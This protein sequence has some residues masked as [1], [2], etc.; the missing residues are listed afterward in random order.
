MT[1]ITPS[2]TVGQLVRERPSRA[3]VFERLGLDYCCGGKRSLAAACAERGLDAETVVAVLEAADVPEDTAV[4]DWSTASVDELC[5]HIVGVHHARLRE[6]LPR[7]S[8]LLEKVERAH[9]AEQPE[10]RDVRATFEEL[11]TELEQHTNE[12]ER[13]LFPA[14]RAAASGAAE[15]PATIPLAAFEDEH[16]LA[17][18]LLAR[19]SELTGG[20]DTGAARCNTHRAALDALRALQADLHEHIHEENNL[21]FPRFT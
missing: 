2:T 10:L 17:G 5:D 13:V 11:R 3:R 15:A 9:G 16:E 19:L 4:T 18:R 6:E 7:L 1:S 20:Y 14:C 21:L 8:T 12:E